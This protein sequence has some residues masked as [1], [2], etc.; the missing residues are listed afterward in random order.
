MQRAAYPNPHNFQPQVSNPQPWPGSYN[1][2]QYIEPSIPIQEGIPVAYPNNA[3]PSSR[4]SAA[5]F[6]FYLSLSNI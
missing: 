2:P 1:H 6:G 5:L 4:W 3:V